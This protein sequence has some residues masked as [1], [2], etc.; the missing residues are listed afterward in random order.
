[1]IIKDI[2]D[3]LSDE[4]TEPCYCEEPDAPPSS[5]VLLDQKGQSKTEHIYYTRLAFNS[6]APTMYEAAELA[7]RVIAAVESAIE[8]DSVCKIE[9][10]SNYNFTDT[11]SKRYRYQ[12]L[13]D[14]THY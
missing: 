13:F 6:I 3:Y 5:Y 4:L 2:L 8:L 10:N 11:S 12:T 7:E 14:I 1:M 9:L